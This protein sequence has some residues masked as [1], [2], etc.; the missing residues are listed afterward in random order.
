LARC[1]RGWPEK[2]PDLAVK[3][4][5]EQSHQ[6][7][8]VRGF[9]YVSEEGVPL[10]LWLVQR[11]EVNRPQEVVASV[12]DEAGWGRW[13]RELGP[14]FGDVLHAGGNPAP[15]PYPKWDKDRFAPLGTMLQGGKRAYALITPRGVGRT[16]WSEL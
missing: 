12:L 2:P 16:R 4:A 9:D 8:R 7:V 6:G 10:R 5:G 3:P 11:G 14:A 15:S 1:F 13:L